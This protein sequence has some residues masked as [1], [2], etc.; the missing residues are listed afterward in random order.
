MLEINEKWQ[1]EKGTA[2]SKGLQAVLSNVPGC[3]WA[4]RQFFIFP[5]DYPNP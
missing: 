4:R 3:N 5:V 1:A 2:R